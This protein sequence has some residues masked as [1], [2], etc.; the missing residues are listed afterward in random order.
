MKLTSHGGQFLRAS[1]AD[2]PAEIVF[3]ERAKE[4]PNISLKTPYVPEEFVAGDDGRIAKVRLR[5]AETGEVEELEVGGAFVAIG[6]A[7]SEDDVAAFLLS[8]ACF[9]AAAG[10]KNHGAAIALVFAPLALW[11]L[12]RKFS[13]RRLALTA[14]V[15]RPY[16]RHL[17]PESPPRC[18]PPLRCPGVAPCKGLRSAPFFRERGID[19]GSVRLDHLPPHG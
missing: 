8:I 17:P 10:T 3:G 19:L 18:R 6:R 16:Q 14:G 4:I 2:D 15:A 11:W 7:V 5:H 13:V 1:T 12:F 9:G